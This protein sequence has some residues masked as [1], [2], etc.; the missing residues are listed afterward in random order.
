MLP[1]SIPQDD[2]LPH[3]QPPDPDAGVNA[4]LVLRVRT[5]DEAAFEQLFRQYYN[6]LCVFVMSYV[7]DKE[8][9]EELVEAVFT[10][11]WQ[12]REQWEITVNLRAYLY[13]A[14][15][16]QVLDYRRHAAV[17]SRM[18]ER[19]LREAVSPGQGRTIGPHEAYEAA[20]L[21]AAM[22]YAI[23][24][25]PER[26]RLVFTLRWQHHLSYAEIAETLGIA[27]KT[28]ETQLNRALKSLR[29]SL[30]PYR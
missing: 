13:T 19:A 2:G 17:E 14:A 22:V 4:A 26:C 1:E 9:A 5:G 18:R 28:V 23:E 8:L 15:R 27:V 24:H 21:D 11:I 20:E 16:Y 25:L 6:P 12:H 7:R 30:K 3:D 29:A 10:R